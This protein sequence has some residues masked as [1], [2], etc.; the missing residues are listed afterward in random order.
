MIFSVLF[1]RFDSSLR[2]TSTRFDLFP[3]LT[4][5]AL[6]VLP[7]PPAPPSLPDAPCST[8]AHPHTAPLSDPQRP[9]QRPPQRPS[10]RPPQRPPQQPPLISNRRALG[11]CPQRNRLRRQSAPQAHTHMRARTHTRTRRSCGRVS[12]LAFG[13]DSEWVGSLR[14]PPSS[15]A[16]QCKGA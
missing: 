4:L 6:P 12:P 16:A 13:T 7:S 8:G 11:R 1:T 14:S 10:Q 3:T 2:I 9:Q 5:G 15:E